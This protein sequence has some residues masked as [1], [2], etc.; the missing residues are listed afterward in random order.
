VTLKLV[1][2]YGDACN[3]GGGNPEVVRQKLE[4]LKRH[5]DAV[6]R[7]YDSIIKSTSIEPLVLLQREVDADRATASLRGDTPLA[8]YLERAWVGTPEQIVDRLEALADV[9]ADYV[10]VYLPR[11]AYDHEPMRRFARNVI[12]HL[13]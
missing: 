2:Q 3:V 9:G 4:V 13:Q 1:A 6:G 8:Q 11:V 10:L 7:D 5:C 12:P